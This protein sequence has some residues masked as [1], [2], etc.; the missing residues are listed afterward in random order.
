MKVEILGNIS[1]SLYNTISKEL[2]NVES[3]L[4]APIKKEEEK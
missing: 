2:K 1:K 4:G 3:V